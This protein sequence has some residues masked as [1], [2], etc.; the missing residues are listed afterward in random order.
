MRRRI[1]S[2]FLVSFA[3]FNLPAAAQ[4]PT[5]PTPAKQSTLEHLDQVDAGPSE[6]KIKSVPIPQLK[7]QPPK[8]IQ[9]TDE[10]TEQTAKEINPIS[11]AKTERDSASASF[12]QPSKA[13]EQNEAAP[14][15]AAEREKHI[16]SLES[17]KTGPLSIQSEA[18]ESDKAPDKKI[19]KTS[20][21]TRGPATSQSNKLSVSLN[22]GNYEKLLKSCHGRIENL[23]EKVSGARFSSDSGYYILPKDA[24]PPKTKDSDEI[25]LVFD[26]DDAFSPARC[27][28]MST[29]SDSLSAK[30]LRELLVSDKPQISLAPPRP[31]FVAYINLQSG[32]IKNSIGR[33]R[34]T[35]DAANDV[36]QQGYENKVWSDG[37]I[38]TSLKDGVEILHTPNANFSDS[39]L[40]KTQSISLSRDL[41]LDEAEAVIPR[42]IVT[43]L[44]EDYAGNGDNA[45]L[46]ISDEFPSCRDLATNFFVGGDMPFRHT[47]FI[48]ALAD[49]SASSGT[50]SLDGASL[51][52]ECTSLEG[53]NVMTFNL[54]ERVLNLDWGAALRQATKKL[55]ETKTFIDTDE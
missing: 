37:I 41:A 44:T 18:P 27:Q 55:K 30:E 19:Q 9:E 52:S 32:K 5:M 12:V 15:V 40:T 25:K 24:W 47:G 50:I 51:L 31:L 23:T 21:V 48:F 16:I 36:Y 53:R 20:P 49:N 45:L 13:R 38:V 22:Y 3:A 33:W 10:G 42:D 29:S 11:A 43:R 14:I 34:E 26:G 6:A 2:A 4:T 1:N 39:I 7:T 46:Y 8:S 17:K 28:L 35:L 54:Y